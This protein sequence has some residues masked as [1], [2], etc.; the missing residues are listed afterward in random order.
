MGNICFKY[1]SAVTLPVFNLLYLQISPLHSDR[2]SL[3]GG[4]CQHQSLISQEQE[5]KQHKQQGL[6]ANC[7]RARLCPAAPCAACLWGGSSS[8]T[9]HAAEL[10]SFW[11]WGAA[12]IHPHFCQA[13]GLP[14]YSLLGLPLGLVEL[15]RAASRKEA[16]GQRSPPR[17]LP[18]CITDW[19]A[20]HVG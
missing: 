5:Q 16:D 3:R 7:R 19:M 18:H 12:M 13:H 2:R 1:R 6:A 15:L 9:R 10:S 8:S 17:D 4:C 11:F 14:G 20:C